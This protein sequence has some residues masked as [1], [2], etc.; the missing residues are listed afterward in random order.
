MAPRLPTPTRRLPAARI[1]LFSPSPL[2]IRPSSPHFAQARHLPQPKPTTTTTRRPL[3]TTAPRPWLLSALPNLTPGA[4]HP[5][6]PPK[7]LHAR[8]LL[9]YPPAHV[10]TLIAD[11]DSYTHFLPHCPHSRVT[12]WTTP[13]PTTSTTTT[14]S[15]PAQARSTAAAAT[16]PPAGRDGTRHPALADL[17]VGWGPFTQTYTSRVYCVPGSVVEAVSGSAGTSIPADVLRA[18]GYGDAD[19]QGG[20]GGEGKKM[21]GIFESLVTRWTVKPVPQQGGQEGGEWSQVTL[22]VTF[23]F[24]NPALGFAVGQLA[25]EKVDEMVAAFEGR[26]RQLYGGR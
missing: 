22:S 14:P 13:K 23:Q 21:E 17:T 12:R 2:P 4:N 6:P 1:P 26:A 3:S 25:D 9:P 15:T 11:I 16:Q 7:T 20:S 19:L 10:Y 24:S 5:P 18:V 8:R